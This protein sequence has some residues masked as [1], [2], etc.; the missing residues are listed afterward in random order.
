MKLR[1][2]VGATLPRVGGAPDTD[3]CRKRTRRGVGSFVFAG[4]GL[5]SGCRKETFVL[6]KKWNAD[7]LQSCLLHSCNQIRGEEKGR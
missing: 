7:A 1:H 5:L 3:T 2:G 6:L 4:H